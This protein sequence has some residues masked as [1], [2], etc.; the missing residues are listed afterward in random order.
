MKL[1]TID[2]IN[3]KD[4]FLLNLDQLKMFVTAAETGS[5]SAAG[6][7]LGKGQSAISLGIS[8]LETDLGFE[9]FDRS[10]RKPG[11]TP[12]GQRLLTYAYAVLLQVDDLKTTASSIFEGDE[13]RLRIVLDDAIFLPSFGA[14]LSE[15]GQKF[16][17][18]ELEF[19]SAVS[20]EIPEMIEQGHAEIGLLFSCGKVQKGVEQ[21]FI[22]N[23]PFVSVSRPDYPLA[24]IQTIGANELL[25]YRQLLL[26]SPKGSVLDQFPALSTE[27][28][29][30]AS[31]Y[32]IRELVLQGL[33]WAYL[34]EHM[35]K[36]I[37][38]S[39]QL[40]KLKLRFEHKHWSPPVECITLK[41][42]R[43]G[44]AFG[45]LS[46]EVKNILP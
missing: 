13:T 9:L 35:V 41:N 25:P 7:A 18:T 28:W 1:V 21:A 2:N 29:T 26:R 11:L 45:W 22:G 33:G 6:R 12:D 24:K 27:I 23:L 4:G 17:A 30:A 20:P 34:P 42:A 44:P 38:A 5:F 10:T 16:P 46:K 15:F 3:I 36:S 19:F 39:G 14:I 37:I 40:A 8:N 31:F 32:A 43:M